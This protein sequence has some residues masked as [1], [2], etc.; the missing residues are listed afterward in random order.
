MKNSL[1][2]T[3]QAYEILKNYNGDNSYI[4]NLKNDVYAYKKL[5]L[6]DFHI[7][8][9]LKN[10]NFKPIFLNKIIKIADWFGE[11]KQ[12]EWNLEFLPEKLLVGYYLGETNDFYHMYVKY[13]KSQDKMVSVFI[14]KKALLNPL[15]LENFNDKVV[16]FEKYNKMAQ[17]VLKPQQE[18][19]VKFL[20]TRKK[21]ILAHQMG[22]RKNNNINCFC[23]R[24]QI[25][26]NID[27]FS[28]IGKKYM[29]KRTK[30]IR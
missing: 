2:K 11:K 20:T 18:Q 9:I 13:R 14:P 17:I 22:G 30:T 29:G 15:F 4:I 7:E 12:I 23:F 27:N 28:S 1:L 3:N 16:D 8:Y 19:G 24:R 5:T 26:K 25:R 21:A 6:N 10:Y